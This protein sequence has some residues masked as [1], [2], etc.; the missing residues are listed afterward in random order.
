MRAHSLLL[1]IFTRAGIVS[2][3]PTAESLKTRH[4]HSPYSHPLHILSAAAKPDSVKIPLPIPTGCTGYIRRFRR[5][6]VG[7]RSYSYR[8]SFSRLTRGLSIA[9]TSTIETTQEIK[10]S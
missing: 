10:K 9:N 1:V 8:A 5:V 3:S 6:I 2:N 7:V 4:Q